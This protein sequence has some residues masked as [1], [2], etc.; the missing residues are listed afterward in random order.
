MKLFIDLEGT[1]IN[2]WFDMVPVMVDTMREKIGGHEVEI[3]SF[4]VF[5]DEDLQRFNIDIKPTIEEVFG[6]K[7]VKCHTVEEI[8]AVVQKGTGLYLS[9]TDFIQ[10]FGKERAFQEFCLKEKVSGTLFDDMVR[11]MT[12]TTPEGLTITTVK[13]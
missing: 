5:N 12:I 10:L 4:A 3:F 13:V 6:C 11:D 9:I 2:D 7:V 1:V 8:K